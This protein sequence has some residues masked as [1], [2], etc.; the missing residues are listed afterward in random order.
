MK[1]IP[2]VDLLPQYEELKAEIDEAVA[3]V[4]R[5]SSFIG[6]KPVKEFEEAMKAYTG[7]KF[8]VGVANATSAGWMVLSAM[9]ISKPE[10]EVITTP[11][12][13]IPTAEYVTLAGGTPV[14]A[15]IDP[16]TYQISPEAIE[17][18]ITPRT[19]AIMPV[20]L[21]GI[22]C[23]MDRILAIGNKH[24]IPVLEDS[25]Q[26]QGAEYKGRKI[27][28]MGVASCWSFFPSKNLGCWGDGGMLTTDDDK[29]ERHV[30]M[31]SNHGRLEKFTHEIPGANERLDALHATVLKIKLTRLD[32]W[33]AARREIA[34][35]Y[36]EEL[37][38]VNEITLP[39]IHEGSTPVWHLYV[40]RTANRE[41]LAASLK[42]KTIATG[43]HYPL[44]LHLQPAMS[45]AGKEG[46]FPEA[47][48]A[49]REILSIPM[50]PHMAHEDARTVAAAIKEHFAKNRATVTA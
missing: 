26:A 10:H 33:N 4:I 40:I 35:I 23:D 47:E 27:G 44:P 30:R 39:E 22:P 8:A 29:L 12:T 7:A 2:F 42:E 32:A 36:Q 50:Y 37:A 45:F 9:G 20:H 49:T 18:K 5:T 21:Y 13:A 34:A 14:F 24:G 48:R 38:D 41:A 6:G 19:K 15:D 25:A 43:L 16:R 1:K 46:D 31:F 3:N 28:S 17:A 11:L